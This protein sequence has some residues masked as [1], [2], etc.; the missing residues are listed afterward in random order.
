MRRLFWSAILVAAGT[1]V[2]AAALADCADPAEPASIPD[3]SKASEQDMVAAQQ[4]VKHYLGAMED[5]LKC[6]ESSGSKEA[7]NLAVQRM[8]TVAARFNNTVRAFRSKK[9]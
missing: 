2:S 8:Q 7:F 4:E 6:L 3:A 1:A 5:R 9:T